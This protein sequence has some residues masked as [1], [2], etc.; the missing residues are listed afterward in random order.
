[1]VVADALV[2]TP[3]VP[4]PVFRRKLP[5]AV[6]IE[7]APDPPCTT[8]VLVVFVLPTV[9]TWA[10]ASVPKL[11]A[12]V[13][14]FKAMFVVDVVSPMMMVLVPAVPMLMASLDASVPILIVVPPEDHVPPAEPVRVVKAIVVKVPAAGV[15]PP[16]AG[17][18][19]N[20]D[21]KL[22]GIK[23]VF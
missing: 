16:I 5:F 3:I 18:A 21:A 17:G 2:P 20:T 14:T 4:V 7:E 9:V 6:V 13:P 19:A 15:V 11:R 22:L 8:K 1:M 10:V 23:A 12:P